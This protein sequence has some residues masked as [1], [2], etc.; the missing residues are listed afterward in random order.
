MKKS[1]RFTI[2][3]MMTAFISAFHMM[4]VYAYEHSF[5]PSHKDGYKDAFNYAVTTGKAKGHLIYDT[6]TVKIFSRHKNET[7]THFDIDIN[8]PKYNK[9]SGIVRSMSVIPIYDETIVRPA[10][11]A[12]PPTDPSRIMELPGI[13]HVTVKTTRHPEGA[14]SQ[15]LYFETNGEGYVYMGYL[16]E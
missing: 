16:E 13:N 9:D 2:L 6:G 10:N 8:Y 4:A 12:P 3:L 15:M 11:E 7:V 1:K 5:V 14:R